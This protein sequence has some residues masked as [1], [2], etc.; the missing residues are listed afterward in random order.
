MNL[1]NHQ[2]K[3]LFFDTTHCTIVIKRFHLKEKDFNILHTR[4][5]KLNFP[6]LIE[7]IIKNSFR[8]NLIDYYFEYL[9]ATKPQKV[10]TFIDNNL[11][12]YKLKKK[13]P[14]IKFISIQ[15]GHRTRYRDFFSLLK[16]NKNLNLQCDKIFVANLGFG[17][18]IKKFIKCKVVPLGFFKNNFIKLKKKKSLRNSLLF[19]SQYREHQKQDDF[20]LVEKK[21]TKIFS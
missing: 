12:F 21:I 7:A 17:K 9:N 11:V 16:K 4:L 20:F 15:S 14:N 3:I 19:I 6:L 8:L 18:I 2:K 10:F 1:L 13:F 5:E